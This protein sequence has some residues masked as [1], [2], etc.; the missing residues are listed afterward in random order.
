LWLLVQR[1]FGP[2]AVDLMSSAALTHAS[3]D[4]RR[5]PFVS[6]FASPEAVSYDVFRASL[7]PGVAYYAH[8]PPPLI[9]PLLAH[10]RER[11]AACTVVVP[12][13]EGEPWWPFLVGRFECVR[14]AQVGEV[15]ALWKPSLHSSSGFADKGPLACELWAF[16]VDFS[17]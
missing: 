9:M 12:R 14:L 8:P 6:R 5:L 16:A 15:D 1:A 2:H 7:S 3:V 13:Q 17:T 4:G 10:L 11:Q